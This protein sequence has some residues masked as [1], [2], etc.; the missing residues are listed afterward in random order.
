MEGR[1]RRAAEPSHASYGRINSLQ[2]P[3][4]LPR[5]PEGAGLLSP[6]HPGGFGSGL[7]LWEQPSKTCDSA[8]NILCGCE[9][10]PLFTLASSSRDPSFLHRQAQFLKLSRASGA[11]HLLQTACATRSGIIDDVGLSQAP[12][13][14][15]ICNLPLFKTLREEFPSWCS[16]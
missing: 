6:C 12:A 5:G 3:L 11:S 2:R 10:Q 4:E 7:R 9:R 13:G 1:D 8:A 15:E 14:P 16:G